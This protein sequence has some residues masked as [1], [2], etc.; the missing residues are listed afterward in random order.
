MVFARIVG[1]G[2]CNLY[3]TEIIL[4]ESECAENW[5]VFCEQTC[6]FLFLFKEI[7]SSVSVI[8]QLLLLSYYIS[9]VRD[10]GVKWSKVQLTAPAGGQS[11]VTDSRSQVSHSCPQRE[12]VSQQQENSWSLEQQKAFQMV[13]C[14]QKL[15]PFLLLREYGDLTSALRCRDP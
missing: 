4:N 1:V 14:F 8:L 11:G 6:K 7:L 3:L 9:D 5:R 12:G 15:P 10:K 2:L 13:W